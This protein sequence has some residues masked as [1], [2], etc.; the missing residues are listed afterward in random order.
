M[1]SDIHWAA[2]DEAGCNALARVQHSLTVASIMTPRSRLMTC[3]PADSVRAIMLENTGRFSYLPVRDEFGA[4]L[5]LYKAEAWFDKETPE[6]L[7]G[8]DFEPLS[9]D[10]VVGADTPIIDFLTGADDPPTRLVVSGA[11]IVGMVGL[12]DL[13]QLPVRTALFALITS[14]E[15]TMA[16]WI[17][18]K[19]SDN[20][21]G[22]L[23]ILSPG[24]QQKVREKVRKLKNDDSFVSEILC[25]EFKDK[26]D[27][28]R[29]DGPISGSQR[30]LE[31]EFAA[32]EKL[33]N[34]LAHAGFYAGTFQKTLEVRSVIR[35]AMQIQRLLNAG[36][37]NEMTRGS[38]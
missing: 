36:T 2:R 9:E 16:N 14:L 30:Q 8:A 19:W 34:V 6:Q 13:Q 17:E 10:H 1:E 32:M 18:A 27:I 35:R 23:C 24:R 29:K 22:W 11:G 37:A 38:M 3:R 15:I 28:V 31:R 4:I 5:G 33:R 21:D 12:S 26:C 7:V 20:A 25:T